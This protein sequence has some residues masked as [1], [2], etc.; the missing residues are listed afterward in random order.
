MFAQHTSLL[1]RVVLRATVTDGTGKRAEAPG[2]YAIGKTATADKPI[3]GEYPEGGPVL[4]SFI[5]AFPGYDP[6]YVLLVSLDEPK[7]LD[8]ARKHHAAGYVAAPVFRRVVERV[9]PVLGIMPVGD[10]VA[11]DGFLGMRRQEDEGAQK[12]YDALAALL[13]EAGY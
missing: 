5:G 4:S 8:P 13:A 9:A 3:N 7:G 6:H 1:M 12:E 2:Y 11:F 10:D